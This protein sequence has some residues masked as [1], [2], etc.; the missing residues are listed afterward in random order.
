MKD[1]PTDSAEV[2]VVT[3][4]AA[5]IGRRIVERLLAADWTVWVLDLNAPP[6][7]ADAVVSRLHY[8]RCDL[9]R[10]DEVI[11]AFTRI[12]TA[13]EAIDAVVCSGGAVQVCELERT[14]I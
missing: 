9:R 8:A 4:G 3:G 6:T 10:S 12:A 7:A 1:R 13:T 2:A 14:A 11:D 5:G